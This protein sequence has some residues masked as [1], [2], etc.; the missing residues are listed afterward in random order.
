MSVNKILRKIYG[1]KIKEGKGEKRKIHNI[2]LNE[3]CPLAN[4]INVIR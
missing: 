4:I 1:P 3:T 2:E